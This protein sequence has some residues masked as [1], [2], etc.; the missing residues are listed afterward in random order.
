[1]RS[2]RLLN[3]GEGICGR[4]P[5]PIHVRVDNRGHRC[6]V[7]PIDLESKG[8]GP[9][10]REDSGSEVYAALLQGGLSGDVALR[11]SQQMLQILMDSMANAVF[12]KDRQSRYLGCNQVFASFAGVEPSALVGLSDR[13]MPW[14]D[15]Q[16]FNAD[17]FLDWDQVVIET[18]EPR[19]GIL[20][21]LQSAAGDLRWLQTNK[22]PLRDL[23]GEV[24]GVLGTFEDVTER[25][26]AEEQLRS[27]LE[28]LDERVRLR[29]TQL[30][31]ANE[32][33]RREVDDRVRIQ[34]EERQQRAYAEALRDSAAAM[35]STLDLDEVMEQV[36]GGVE[37]LVSNDLTAIILGDPGIGFEVARHRVGFGY[38][39]TVTGSS[40]A[41]ASLD[42]VQ[43]LATTSGSVV[44][45]DPAHSLGPAKSVVGALMRIGDQEIGILVAESATSGFFTSVH[46]DRLRAI[47]DQAAAA[48]SNARLAGQASALAATEER[49]RLARELHDAVNQTLWT[50]AL[51]ADSLL[52]EASETSPLRPRLERLRQLTRGALAE[53]RTLMLELRPAELTEAPLH[54][55]IEQL[56]TALE[57]RKSIEMKVALDHVELDPH[58]RLVF[59]RVA[60]EAL[61]NITK[62]SRATA[63][64]ITLTAGSC[65]E[66]RVRDDGCGFD[67]H[68]VPTGHLGL[69]IMRERAESI[70]ATLDVTTSLG[71]GTELRLSVRS[72]R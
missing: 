41:L 3:G 43:H 40:D 52:R 23:T 20:E 9:G 12:W 49:Q 2:S 13:D 24:I 44:V 56:I 60:Q 63:V 6:R 25:R 48:I 51:T 68:A 70:G 42:I 14:A 17:W 22:V 59:Y 46:G 67:S 66:L 62:H 5:R 4:A 58:T 47:A 7:R 1:M 36:L 29:T 54:E 71:T 32:S 53:M 72:H 50:A 28:Q 19:Y 64:A 65:I 45:E 21:R 37:R 33:L 10:L 26:Q 34:A 57:G 8:R 30:V 38:T 27:T 35:S 16:D 18:G 31:R 55:L 11:A 69:T 39:A 15:D 61:S